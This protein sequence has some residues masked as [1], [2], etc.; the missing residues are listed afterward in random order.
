MPAGP[1][2]YLRNE[3]FHE[4]GVA[5]QHEHCAAVHGHAAAARTPAAAVR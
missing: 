5:M 1:A 2:P 3:R 4:H